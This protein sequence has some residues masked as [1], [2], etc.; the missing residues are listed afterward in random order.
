MWPCLKGHPVCPVSR[1]STWPR[2]DGNASSYQTFQGMAAKVGQSPCAS[3]G[4]A[5]LATAACC[6][7]QSGDTT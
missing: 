7:E 6:L 5:M 3:T 4:A 2:R 1:W